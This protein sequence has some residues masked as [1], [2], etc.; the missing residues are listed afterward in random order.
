M[1]CILRARINNSVDSHGVPHPTDPDIDRIHDAGADTNA[2]VNTL[3]EGEANTDDAHA[4]LLGPNMEDAEHEQSVRRRCGNH[5]S[6]HSN[7]MISILALPQRPLEG[8][9][10]VPA[11]PAVSALSTGR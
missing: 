11:I 8:P 2:S 1:A 6:L 3:C 4:G 5:V 7:L 9:P 10:L